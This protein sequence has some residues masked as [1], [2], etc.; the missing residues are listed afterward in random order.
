V[1]G[2]P[3]LPIPE[4][5]VPIDVVLPDQATSLSLMAYVTGHG[6]GN[7]DSGWFCTLAC[8]EGVPMVEECV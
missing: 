5:F 2:N 7:A 8:D 1:Y 3:D 4:Q 6:R